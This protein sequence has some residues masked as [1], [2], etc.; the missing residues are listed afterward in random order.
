[1]CV[2][3]YVY[4]MSAAVGGR[5]NH[6]SIKCRRREQRDYCACI[7]TIQLPKHTHTYSW[8]CKCFRKWMLGKWVYFFFT[9]H[10]YLPGSLATDLAGFSV[11][12]RDQVIPTGGIWLIALPGRRHHL[13]CISP[14]ARFDFQDSN[15]A[16]LPRP[17]QRQPIV[18]PFY[19]I[20]WH[21]QCVYLI[22]ITIN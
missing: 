11:I 10:A 16:E 20:P 18:F 21:P 4:V 13:Q 7:H 19:W 17:V 15:F 12:S 6:R 9:R 8:A 14:W 2:C 22:T 3:L 1:M 5:E